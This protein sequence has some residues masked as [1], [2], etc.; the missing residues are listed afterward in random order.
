MLLVTAH[1]I[2]HAMWQFKIDP[3]TSAI[4]YLTALGDL[5]G[6]SLLMG[7]FA[8]LRFVGHEYEGRPRPT[9]LDLDVTS[10]ISLLMNAIGGN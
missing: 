3:D 9:E 8:F 4:P 5:L 10:P 6:S 2:I 1:V 7:A